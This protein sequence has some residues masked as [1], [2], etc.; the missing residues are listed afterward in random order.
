MNIVICDVEAVYLQSLKEKLTD[1]AVRNGHE[2]AM[3]VSA[4]HSSEELLNAYECGMIMDAFFMDIRIPGEMSGMEAAKKIFSTNEGLPIVFI[5]NYA[6]YACEGYKVNALRYI[7]KPILQ[8]DV[9]ECMDIIWRRHALMQADVL[10]LSTVNQTLRLPAHTIMLL[11]SL[12][13]DVRIVTI[14]DAGQYT[15]RM[16]LADIMAQAPEGMLVQCHR[17]YAVNLMYVRRFD[18]HEIRMANGEWVPIS[19]NYADHFITAF[20]SFYQG[21]DE[22]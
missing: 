8:S 22:A 14:D 1:W 18:R 16:K 21:G 11:E 20:S 5:T 4:F 9:D 6:D 19:R 10:T 15:V 7:R 17:S 3:H 2:S 13:H 12:N